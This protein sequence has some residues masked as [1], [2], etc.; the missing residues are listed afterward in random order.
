MR[1]AF[2]FGAV[3]IL[4]YTEAI[5]DMPDDFAGIR[6]S[7]PTLDPVSEVAVLLRDVARSSSEQTAGL[8]EI[9]QAVEV[10]DG[11]T[12]R[13]GQMVGGAVE[14]ASLMQARADRLS[15]GVKTIRLRQ[16]CAEEARAMAERAARVADTEGPESAVRRFHHPNG[17]FRYRDL[18]IVVADRND[19]FRAFGSD[20]GK[21][22]KLRQEALPG[23][24]QSA[25]RE[26]NWRAVDQGGGW[27]EFNGRHPVTKQ[28]VEKI[29]YIA[30][31]LGGRWAVQC[32]VNRGDG[33]MPSRSA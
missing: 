15:D 3:T 21:A 18:Y 12:Q 26:A 7:M 31:A 4:H 16:G 27:I 1:R 13:N 2:Y 30:P 19:Y 5:A 22:G 23:D 20:P 8:Q 10:L 14:T 24:D 9:A 25:I 28:L 33:L 29:G 11:I 6:L 32:S 17:E